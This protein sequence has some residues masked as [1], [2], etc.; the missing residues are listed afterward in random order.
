M[1][2]RISCPALPWKY[3]LRVTG[4]LAVVPKPKTLGLMTKTLGL[5]INLNNTVVLVVGLG[6]M[7]MVRYGCHGLIP[8]R[9]AV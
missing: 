7:M 9:C 3:I 4:F 2:S 8:R 5:Y 1:G 6:R